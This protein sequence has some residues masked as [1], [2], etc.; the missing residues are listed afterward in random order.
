VEYINRITGR[1]LVYPDNN[2]DTTPEGRALAW[3]IEDDKARNKDVVTSVDALLDDDDER[4][5]RQRY[6]LASL[7]L[8]IQSPTP[9]D[10]CELPSSNTNCDEAT[11]RTVVVLQLENIDV[12]GHI[13]DDL[14][15]LTGL[16]TIDLT[17]NALEGTIPPSWGDHLT[18]LRRLNLHDNDLTGTIP[19]SLGALT[20]LTALALSG[21]KLHGTIPPS[22]GAL[23]SLRRLDLQHNEL[24]GLI[25]SSLTALP[26]LSALYLN[27]NQINGAMPFC[28]NRAWPS[29]LQYLVADC[30]YVS[31][32]CCT[33]CCPFGFGG[34]PGYENCIA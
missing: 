28:Q 17:S 11:A 31:C 14:S 9:L 20:G 10:S 22:L 4:S 18:L 27:N 8:P 26:A 21:N 34:I 32:P 6:A 25:P 23:A 7:W 5:L 15:L 1:M 24:T 19:S 12:H 3:L 13:P 16:I 2:T 33:Q 30:F 29:L